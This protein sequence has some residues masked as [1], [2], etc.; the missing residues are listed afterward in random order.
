MTIDEIIQPFIDSKVL[1][2]LKAREDGT[3]EYVI[4]MDD[5]RKSGT[6]VIHPEGVQP[7]YEWELDDGTF[8]NWYV[9]TELYRDKDWSEMVGDDIEDIH[10]LDTLE[11]WLRDNTD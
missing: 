2:L 4:H 10:D 11:E 3:R 7:D 9:K 1:E 8:L 6:L 5:P